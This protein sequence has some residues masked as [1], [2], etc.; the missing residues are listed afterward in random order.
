MKHIDIFIH[1]LCLLTGIIT[2]LLGFL[3]YL[4]YRVKVIRNYAFFILTTTFT[5]TATTLGNYINYFVSFQTSLVSD[6]ISHFIFALFL[7]LI[8]YT[9]SLFALGII[10]KKIK[11]FIQL[12][13]I[14]PWIC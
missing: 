11:S 10:E 9:L 13:V 7:T 5:V 12:I 4:K 8:Y 1:L 2:A 3:L 14:F 6:I